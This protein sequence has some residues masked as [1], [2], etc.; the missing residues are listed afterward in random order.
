MFDVQKNNSAVLNRIMQASVEAHRRHLGAEIL[1]VTGGKVQSGPFKGMTVPTE[2]SWGDGDLAAKALGSYE[3]ELHGALEAAIAR[4]PEVIVNVGC[5]EGYYANGLAKR[6][7]QAQ[8]HAFDIDAKA[9]ELC[10]QMAALDGVGDQVTVGGRCTRED[11]C[12]LADGRNALIVMDCEGAELELLAAESIEALR[13]SVIFV[14]CHDFIGKPVTPT[15]TGLFEET[16]HVENIEEGARN[17]NAYP[18]LRRIGSFERWLAVCEFR[19]CT[20]N[21]LSLTP[22]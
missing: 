4:Q 17:P 18:L 10:R 19:P 13:G 11:L 9:Q 7:P 2:V 21:W 16:H 20:M 12:A 1:R 6:L 15:L 14:E 22:R 8:C 3:A 5:A